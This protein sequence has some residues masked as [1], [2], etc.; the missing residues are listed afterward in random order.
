MLDTSGPSSRSPD[1][2][3]KTLQSLPLGPLRSYWSLAGH[4]LKLS[5]RAKVELLTF[6]DAATAATMRSSLRQ[7]PNEKKEEADQHVNAEQGEEETDQDSANEG[8]DAS[9]EKVVKLHVANFQG[10]LQVDFSKH[11][12]WE[13][14]GIFKGPS[15]AQ[16]FFWPYP[17]FECGMDNIH[18]TLA[19][20]SFSRFS[21]F[22]FYKYY[23]FW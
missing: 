2:F 22:F 3:L 8:I 10:S 23:C 7:Q 5:L 6:S 13:D 20:L 19:L 21:F 18:R 14:E 17:Q 12:L 4:F 11:I 1:S 9:G 15:L 16:N